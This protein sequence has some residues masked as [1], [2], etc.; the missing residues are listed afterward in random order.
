MNT[1]SFLPWVIY[2][3][4]GYNHENGFSYAILVFLFIVGLIEYLNQA[5]KG[6]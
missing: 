6:Q 2:L 4:A 1:M 5:T 3:I